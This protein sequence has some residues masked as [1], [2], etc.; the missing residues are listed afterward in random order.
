MAGRLGARSLELRGIDWWDL[1][2]VTA[3]AVGCDFFPE[4]RHSLCEPFLSY[5]RRN[6]G[7]ERFGYPISEPQQETIERWTGTVQYF[8]RRR[9][10]H[11]TELAG[12]RYE[13]LLGR[14]G[15]DVH[16][17]ARPDVCTARPPA[18]LEAAIERVPFRQWLGCP[19]EL[20]ADVPAAVQR[21]SGGVMIWVDLGG[22]GKDIFVAYR[23]SVRPGNPT[24]QQRFNDTWQEGVDPVD[25][26]GPSGQP[27]VYPPR[28]GFGKVYHQNFRR[29][30]ESPGFGIEPERAERATVQRFTSGATVLLLHGEGNVYAFGAE[31]EQYAVAPK[32]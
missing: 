29:G 8:E 30:P 20:Y 15:A 14:L 26:F 18:P 13:V 1:P 27:G 32:S 23:S 28:R 3:P 12:T 17:A 31:P 2:Q 5:W 4:T 24:V 16:A 19:S 22:G 6:G 9:M 7:L 21:T 11:H 10:E 25:Y